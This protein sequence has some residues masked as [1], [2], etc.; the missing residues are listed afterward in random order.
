MNYG[1]ISADSHVDLTWL[2]GDLFTSRAPS[3]YTELVPI[4]VQTPDG[5]KWRVGNR[6]MTGMGG[7]GKGL[8][9]L[10]KGES[11]KLDRVIDTGFFEDGKKGKAHPADPDRRLKDMARDGVDAEVLYGI[12]NTS[13]RIQN[14]DVV[15]V[16]QHIYNGWA[17]EFSKSR[18]GRW[19]ALAAVPNHDPEIAAAEARQA[20]KLGLKGAEFDAG[21]SN[22]PLWHRSW[23]PLWAALE[24]CR[25]PVSFHAISPRTSRPP[26]EPEPA[27]LHHIL[28]KKG[29]STALLG[30][31]GGEFL[32]AIIFS[33]ALDRYPGLR[34]VLGECGVGWIPFALERMDKQYDQTLFRLGLSMNPSDFWRRQ[35]FTTFQDERFGPHQYAYLGEDTIMWGSDYPHPDGTWP[36]SQTYIRENLGDMDST[37]RHK[38]IAGTAAK[39]YGFMES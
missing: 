20:A 23:D 34:F 28:A 36:D 17:A 32:G 24:E 18:P 31:S 35:G 12:V 22:T 8:F 2:P 19:A 37:V 27:E 25:L 10:T 38:I 29:A 9:S 7:I 14:D 21:H 39:L 33:G 15:A 6:E 11:K 1:V 16:V 13:S 26:G 30:P 3:E 5:P 4:G